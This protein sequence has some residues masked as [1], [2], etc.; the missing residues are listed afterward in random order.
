M[1]TNTDNNRRRLI[2]SSLQDRPAS[3]DFVPRPQW[4]IDSASTDNQSNPRNQ[5]NPKNNFAE[6]GFVKSSIEPEAAPSSRKQQRQAY[7]K[8]AQRISI[9]QPGA[10][11]P[12]SRHQ[13]DP[14]ANRLKGRALL[15]ARPSTQGAPDR[16][17]DPSKPRRPT[18]DAVENPDRAVG[19]LACPERRKMRRHQ[20][21]EAKNHKD[22][23]D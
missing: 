10:A 3:V 5:E 9:D 8:Q 6:A 12:Q 1:I 11:K 19:C 13:K 21:V 20:A 23:T 18:N 17:D 4:R 7:H 15:V 2:R 16:D 14:D 22:D